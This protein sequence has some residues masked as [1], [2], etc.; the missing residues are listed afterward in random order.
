MHIFQ[1]LPTVLRRVGD[2]LE[3]DVDFVESVRVYMENFES[4]SIAC[5]VTT[6]VKDSGLERCRPIN[7]LPWA[8]GRVEF[9]PLPSAY[10]LL[11]FLT[12]FRTV[13]QILRAQII[14]ADYLIFSPHTLVGDWPTIAVHEAIKLG[15]PYVIEADIV[16][17]SVAKVGFGRRSPSWKRFIKQK[18]DSTLFER[19][20]RY[21]LRHSALGLFQGQD[22]YDAYAPFCSNP[23]NLYYHIPV[24][25]GDH[26]TES[27]LQKKLDR[28][29]ESRPLR[30]CYAGRAV[31]MKGALDWL[32]VIAELVKGGINVD[33]IWM[34][35]GSLLPDMRKIAQSLH[36][37][38]CVTFTGQ[39]SDRKEIFRKLKASDIFLFCHKTRESA[40]V[41]GEALACGCPMV[42]Y[43]SSYPYKLVSEHGGGIFA[44]LGDWKRLAAIV[45]DLAGN[46]EA[47]RGLT[48]QAAISGRLHDRSLEMQKRID[49]LRASSYGH[50]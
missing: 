38:K 7:E 49:L 2:Q 31:E 8:P 30:I 23:H 27:E 45:R 39:I 43:G 19:S 24:S 46:V 33:A 18:L 14:R 29:S 42:G 4:I 17:E 16:Y 28:L 20:Y 35:D 44:A 34:G 50:T 26:L 6:T 9:I 37:E 25:T 13:K 3:V 47:L 36:I 40:R 48:K 12:N 15:K 1:V 22:V 32:N 5:P 21:C 11:D 10:R 41:L